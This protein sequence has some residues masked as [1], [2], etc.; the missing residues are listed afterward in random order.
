MTL[1]SAKVIWDFLKKEYYGD[2]KIRDMKVLNPVR[3]FEMQKMKESENIKEYSDRLINLAN[4]AKLPGAELSDKRIVQKILVTLLDKF[5]ATIASLE[6]T[7][8]LSNISLAELLNSL[9]VQ[10]QRRLMRN[11]GAVEGSL[12][13]RDKGPQQSNEAQIT[14]QQEEEQLF[15][16]TCFASK[17]SS[18]S[19]LIDSGFTNH[20]TRDKE[21]FNVLDKSIISKVKI[22]NG[23]YL[24]VKGKH[25]LAIESYSG[26]FLEN[27]FKL[28]FEDRMCVI[29]D[30]KGQ[31]VCRVKMRGRSFSF[32]PMDEKL[33]AY[34]SH[35][36]TADRL[37]EEK[38]SSGS[39]FFGQKQSV[40]KNNTIR[41]CCA[42]KP[43][44][45]ES[46]SELGD[47][48]NKKSS[49]KQAARAPT[50]RW[51]NFSGEDPKPTR[52]RV[53]DYT[54]FFRQL[55]HHFN[56]TMSL[57]VD[58]F[59]SKN[60][61]SG[62][63]GVMITSE[64]LMRSSNYLAWASSVELGCKGQGVQD[65][66]ITKSSEGDEKA[67]ALWEKID[68]QL[69]TPSHLVISSQT[70]DSSVLP[71]QTVDNRASHTMENRRGGGPFGRSRPKCSY[72]HKLGHTHDV[73]YSLHGRPPKNVYIAQT[74]TT[75]RK[76]I[77]VKWVYRTKLNVEGSV[78][79]LNA[80]LVMKGYSHIFGVDYSE[81][82]APVA[83]LDT[84]RLLLA[85]V[86]RKSWR[87][88]QLD[89]KSAF[90]NGFLQQQIYV[91]QPQGFSA[92]GYEDKVYLLKKALYGL[93]QAQRAWYSRIDEHL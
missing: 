3:E 39:P 47:Q 29:F 45:P 87:F 46:K 64:P 25:T 26:Q 9:Q 43:T 11:E 78:N 2:D 89:V 20:I 88:F 4:K 53:S 66:I 59:G 37:W 24:S 38:Q 50:R 21:I 52:R 49:A 80:R 58:D 74:E 54:D 18:E 91:E 93:K 77:G 51:K 82:F 13:A 83:R 35:V 70:L 72:C 68:A 28:I 86:A 84:I 75:D 42:K 85:I 71:S 55:Q 14:E 10:E 8:D 6:N 15:V 90:L 5:E 34:P 79:K 48:P 40:R 36:I 30:P 22:G 56:P 7:K 19:W 32:D 67:K 92:R 16:A 31:E 44:P 62:N 12:Q 17:S 41:Q 23:D 65:H 73:R 76:T 1:S 63:S 61:G 60:Q 27:G 33:A 57:G 81:T 69:C